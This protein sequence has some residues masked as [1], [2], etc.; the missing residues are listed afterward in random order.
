MT[1]QSKTN[2]SDL[3]QHA[4]EG[5]NLSA[6]E[7]KAARKEGAKEDLKEAAKDTHR[8]LTDGNL[9]GEPSTDQYL[10][11]DESQQYAY[12]LEYSPQDFEKLVNGKLDFKPTDTQVHGLLALERNG[13]NRTPYVK[14]AMKKLGLKAEELPGGGPGYTNDLTAITDL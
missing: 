6:A 9:P 1:T 12:L 13:Q 10:G 7:E 5:M 3:D 11:S 14:A 4:P 8:F 2:P